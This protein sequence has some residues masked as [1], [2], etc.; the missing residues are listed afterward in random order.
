MS[1]PEVSYADAVATIGTL[2]SLAPR[3]CATNLRALTIDLV[4]KLSMV[5]SEQS[6]DL[7]YSGMVEQD[8][9]HALRNPTPWVNFLYPGQVPISDAGWTREQIA[10]NIILHK[11]LK[12]CFN[13]ESNMRRATNAAIN[14]A[15]PRMFR[16]VPGGLVGV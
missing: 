9:V 1:H 2:P 16:R 7:G 10:D 5:P 8:A 14:V 4:D 13:S 6:A 15:T 3:P 12:G 11:A